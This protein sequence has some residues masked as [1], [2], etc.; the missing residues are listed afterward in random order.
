[1]SSLLRLAEQIRHEI[2]RSLGS[3]LQISEDALTGRAAPIWE[4]GERD[5]AALANGI[6]DGD[7]CTAVEIGCR[8][9]RMLRAAACQ[10][11]R[12]VGIDFSE[13]ATNRARAAIGADSRVELLVSRDL[14]LAPL[15]DSS[16]DFAWSFS[17]LSTMPPLAVA[18]LLHESRRILKPAGTMRLRLFLGRDVLLS[19]DSLIYPRVYR[20]EGFEHAAALAGFEVVD[21][22]AAL[23]SIAGALSKHGIETVTVTLR[24]AGPSGD[25]ETIAAALAPT[26]ALAGPQLPDIEALASVDFAVT[27]AE[28]G[29]RERARQVLQYVETCCRT[30]TIDIR[31]L[32]DRVV[33]RTAAKIE[34]ASRGAS[35]VYEANMR[36]LKEHFPDVHAAVE[37]AEPASLSGVHV[38]ETPQGPAV[39]RDGTC[40]DHAEKPQQAASAWAARALQEKRVGDAPNLFVVGFGAGYHIESL[41]ACG[42]TRKVWCCEP[43][44]AALRAAMAARDLTLCLSSLAG[45]RVGTPDLSNIQGELEL[46]VRPQ[47][48]LL[49]GHAVQ[50]LRSQIV[51]RR[52][53]LSLHP[54]IAVLGPL[55]G[56]TIPIGYYTQA[57]LQR[58]GQHSRGI[59]MSGF[60]KGYE[61]LDDLA[62]SDRGRAVARNA[63]VEMLTATMLQNF[64][65]KPVDVIICMAQAPA[66]AKFLEEMRRRGVV[67][68]LWF[69]EDYLRFT[70]WRDIAKHYDFVFTIQKGECI[71][72]I[73]A[74]GAGTVHYLPTACDPFIHRPVE[75][76]TLEQELWGSQLS[77]VG[78]GYHN[79]QQ[80]FASLAHYP[81]KIWGSEWP[82]CKPFDR[83]VQENARRISPEEYVKIFCATDINL[84]LH[85]STERDGVEPNGDFVNPRTFELA[86]CGA[87]QLVDERTLLG[88][89]F[90]SGKE[91]VTFSSLPDL[92]DK[93]EHY[94]CRPNERSAI[95]AAGRAK[96][97]REHS[98]DRRIEQML[99]VI[100]GGKF[101]HL[102]AREVQSPWTRMVE[103]SSGH[104][105]LRSRCENARARG[106]QPTLDALV[107]DVVTG[108]GKL[109]ETEQKLMFLFHVKK[110]ILRP[111][112]GKREDK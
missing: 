20:R 108:N 30:A 65:E 111:A 29:E 47:N 4:S 79:R 93:I 95:A 2:E 67:T 101:Q 84:N 96:V 66:P 14:R 68:V 32:L 16:A 90:E 87:F 19:S 12:V 75:L 8:T 69:V 60:N 98:Y 36:A 71:E 109:S 112:L 40:L 57:A 55:Q 5:F 74:A 58:F 103:R 83:L 63:Y 18:A 45:L 31:D 39:W 104:E 41:M 28:Q 102:S 24:P 43:N 76:S 107:S 106:E 26:A 56:G 59:D 81:F 48:T 1:M 86:A 80:M 88:E 35:P 42:A 85:S 51:S 61:L 34:T 33:D 3:D 46:L 52:G 17:A 15:A 64:E 23:P 92:V 37:A 38:T 99:S 82:I 105:E 10:F 73:K 9:G 44:V 53:L 27:L 54:R 97:L 70:Y 11:G 6:A 78:A 72:A 49:D 22:S 110:H 94:K 62:R 13:R 21:I 100:Y 50:P 7:S 89:C 77:F 91:I 25:I